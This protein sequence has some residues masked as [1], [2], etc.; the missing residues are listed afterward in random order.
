MGH[1]Y[2]HP[3]VVEALC[4]FLFTPNQPWDITLSGLFHEK[5]K[6]NFPEK[7]FKV[8]LI[9]SQISMQSLP[10]EIT[11]K[12]SVAFILQFF[13]KEKNSLVQ[14]GKDL[15][16]VN[17]LKPYTSWEEFKKM[18]NDNLFA[19]QEVFNPQN[20]K[21]F[22]LRFINK[23]EFEIKEFKINKYFNYYPHFPSKA[24]TFQEFVTK[25]DIPL[26]ESSEKITLLLGT[27]LPSK[28]DSISIVLDIDYSLALEKS[29]DKEEIETLLEHA[30]EEVENTFENSITEDLRNR[31]RR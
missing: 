21:N 28:E 13:N 27:T 11:N 22:H 17:R 12:I 10:Q 4:E 18:I 8:N 6:K 16:A 31:W 30:H 2:Q 1:K 23:M 25:I 3:P 15:L 24:G 14:L 9:G 20:V 29:M 5:I 7:N 26:R 19:Y